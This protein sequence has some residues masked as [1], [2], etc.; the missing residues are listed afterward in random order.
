MDV[1]GD[2]F[3]HIGITGLPSH[4]IPTWTT[5]HPAA[6]SVQHPSGVVCGQF[7]SPNCIC[8]PVIH[9][10]CKGPRDGSQGQGCAQVEGGQDSTG[11]DVWPNAHTLTGQDELTRT[12]FVTCHA[13][14][15]QPLALCVVYLTW[16]R[17]CRTPLHSCQKRVLGFASIQRCSS[18]SLPPLD[19]SCVF[20]SC[21]LGSTLGADNAALFF[22]M[23]QLDYNLV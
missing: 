20:H 8:C 3:R 6:L 16:V 10:A 22:L 23:S 17:C 19:R 2:A 21:W 13:A 1:D 14:L 9:G 15:L 5:Y 12:A 7:C 18:E 11:K 4:P